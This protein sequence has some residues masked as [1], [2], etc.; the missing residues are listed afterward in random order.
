M[1]KSCPDSIEAFNGIRTLKE[2]AQLW[3]TVMML[4]Y[5]VNIEIQS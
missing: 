1:R 3:P 2:D 5:Y 4:Y